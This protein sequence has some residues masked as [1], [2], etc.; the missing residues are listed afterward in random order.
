MAVVVAGLSAQGMT[1]CAANVGYCQGFVDSARAVAISFGLP[2]A[3]L[4]QE[5]RRE[6]SDRGAEQALCWVGSPAIE[7]YVEMPYG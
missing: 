1:A 4:W 7:G 3:E 5:I 6:L 2:W